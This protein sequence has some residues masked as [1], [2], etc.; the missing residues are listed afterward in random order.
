MTGHGAKYHPI[1]GRSAP[2]TWPQLNGF[3]VLITSAAASSLTDHSAKQRILHSLHSALAEPG[4]EGSGIRY[5]GF[6]RPPL[7]FSI[8]V[9]FSQA[10]A[11]I[12]T[13]KGGLSIFPASL[14]DELLHFC[15]PFIPDAYC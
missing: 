3:T 13:S 6:L 9:N 15:I 11:I 12:H 8:C 1:E 5:I 14:A 2:L 4:V 7:P 10:T